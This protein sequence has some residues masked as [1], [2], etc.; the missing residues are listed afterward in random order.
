[1]KILITTIVSIFLCFFVKYIYIKKIYY[2]NINLINKIINRIKKFRYIKIISDALIKSNYSFRIKGVNII[3]T[4]NIVILSIFFSL[5]TFILTY[6]YLNLIF[7]STILS[8]ISFFIPYYIIK[9]NSYR[10]KIKILNIFPNYVVNLKNYTDV[11]N[12]IVE[13]FRR[14]S[15]EEPLNKYIDK[16]N[17]SIQKGVK[18]YDAFETLKNNINIEKINKF[19]T[20]LQFCY[21]YG[22]NFGTLLDK[23]SKIQM[24][25][26]I[27]REKERQKTFSAKLVLMVLILLNIYILFGF[28][29]SNN[30]YYD[31]L[32]KTFVGNIILNINIISYIFIFY[33]YI[34]LN[35]MEE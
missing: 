30:D 31:I 10:K 19:I 13:A 17:V 3:S 33:M 28:V 15:V 25:A 11:N 12:D 21:V 26:N 8:I 4:L 6:R 20:L 24:K 32:V 9:Y 22:G 1:M 5:I 16:F 35:K 14:T 2:K 18:L 29:L 7:S 27:L 34:K 23:F